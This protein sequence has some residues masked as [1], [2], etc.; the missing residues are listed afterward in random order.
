MLW[1]MQCM[2]APRCVPPVPGP[3]SCL[4]RV[5]FHCYSCLFGGLV[6]ADRTDRLHD[7]QPVPVDP[8]VDDPAVCDLVPG[9]GGGLPLLAAWWITAEIP[10]VSA[11]RAHAHSDQVALGD[12]V[13]ESHVDVGKGGHEAANC[14][15]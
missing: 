10:Q 5:A 8:C 7:R 13:F 12:L 9:A 11:R 14:G 6:P 2:R 15:L 3:L 1:R 4:L